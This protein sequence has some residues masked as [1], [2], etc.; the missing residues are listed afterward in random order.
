ML[1]IS[2]CWLLAEPSR[3]YSSEKE[4]GLTGPTLMW[5]PMLPDA[6]DRYSDVK[7]FLG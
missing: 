3:L 6:S 5:L 2:P 4:T 1:A 7:P